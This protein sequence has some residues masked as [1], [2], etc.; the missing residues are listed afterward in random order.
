MRS[1]LPHRHGWPAAQPQRVQRCRRGSAPG[2]C[3]TVGNLVKTRLLPAASSLADGRT[4]TAPFSAAADHL[5]VGIAPTA[6]SG[7]PTLAGTGIAPRSIVGGAVVARTG[8]RAG[9]AE[10]EQRSN[11]NAGRDVTAASSLGRPARAYS[12][13]HG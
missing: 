13:Q 5:T 7:P 1:A 6:S 3:A 9:D 4:P 2:G 8:V 11:R 12:Q 10:A